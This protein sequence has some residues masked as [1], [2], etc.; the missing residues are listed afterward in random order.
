MP[1]ILM[2]EGNTLARQDEAAR[3]GARA[4]SDVYI[5]AIR[6]HFPAL[7]IDRVHAADRG[8]GPPDG[9]ALADYDG[10]VVGGSGLHAYDESFEVRNQIDMLRAYAETGRPILGSCWGLRSHTKTSTWFFY[11]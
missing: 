1:R 4:A 5:E 2:M 7:D 8:Q 10:L 9:R 11:A 3:L 6:S